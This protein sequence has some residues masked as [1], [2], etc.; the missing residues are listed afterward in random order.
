[1]GCELVSV[2]IPTYNRAY[3]V[4]KTIDTALAQTHRQV[5]IVL[6]DD[7][8]TDGTAQLI[9][10][11]YGSDPRVRYIRQENAGVSTARNTGFAHARGEFVA[12]LDSDD[13]WFPH[14]LA[15]QL[16]VFRAHPEVGM[17]WSD[18]EA[19]DMQG[20]VLRPRYLKEMYSAYRHFP[21]DELFA[22]HTRLAT[23]DP[24]L[25]QS[26]GDA[27]V[28]TGMV[29]SAMIMGSLVHTSTAVLRRE[30][31]EKVGGFNSEL[32]RL[33][34]DY[35]FHLRTC[36]LGPVGFVDLPTI[37][38]TRGNPDR[39]TRSEHHLDAA[40]NFLKVIEP[41]IAQHRGEITLSDS[42]LTDVLSE[43]NFWI[44]EAA[45]ERKRMDL[46]T[47]H[48]RLGLGY[49]PFAWRYRVKLWLASLPGT[50]RDSA[51]RAIRTIKPPSARVSEA[52]IP[53]G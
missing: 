9:A 10:D 48:L 46:V 29:Y 23:L 44:A 13:L 6:V 11:R 25:A 43:A 16:A 1:M 53:A 33:G 21:D 39:L 36:R 8:S 32:R 50:L 3:C 38:Y 17:V 35:D 42:Q 47:K 40:I 14:K 7:G 22:T 49:R 41:N 2:V 4:A 52:H 51:L 20:R 15:A 45:W 37:Q 18:M 26:T 24:E 34:E 19:I 5:E 30:R 27:D 28:R 31:L 12:L